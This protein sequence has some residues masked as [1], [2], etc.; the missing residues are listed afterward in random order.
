MI[1]EEEVSI[2]ELGR[3]TE[4][5]GLLVKGRFNGSDGFEEEESGGWWEEEVRFAKRQKQF[6]FALGAANTVS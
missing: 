3:V 1:R 2:L 6:S 4:G 5:E